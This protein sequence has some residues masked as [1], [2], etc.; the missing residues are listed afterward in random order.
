MEKFFFL[1][2][3]I[4]I[5]RIYFPA[6]P[7]YSS[8][9]SKVRCFHTKKKKQQSRLNPL[10][11]AHKRIHPDESN[12]SGHNRRETRN[13]EI[14]FR[15]ETRE[16]ARFKTD[17]REIGIDCSSETTRTSRRLNLVED[18]ASGGRVGGSAEIDK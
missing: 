8:K 7:T 15:R 2:S 18:A 16:G 14:H 4:Y 6:V 5:P 17:S 12:S 3:K 10:L 1:S 9:V 13:A 11:T